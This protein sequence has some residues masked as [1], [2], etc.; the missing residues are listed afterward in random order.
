MLDR[1]PPGT[2]V[3]VADNDQSWISCK[4]TFA[5]DV[6]NGVQLKVE[7]DRGKVIASRELER[8]AL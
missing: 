7:D 4:V 6:G 2:K 5:A 3:W 8:R 1:Y